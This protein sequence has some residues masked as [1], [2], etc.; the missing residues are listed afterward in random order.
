MPSLDAV[1]WDMDGTL[2]DTE[3]SWIA[4]EHAIVEE[5]GGTWNDELATQLVGHDLLVSARFII[6]NSSVTWTPERVV[7]ELISRV[8]ADLHGHVPWRPGALDLLGALRE[9]GVR[10]AL[11]TMSYAALLPP[12]LTALGDLAFDAIVTGDSV[13]RGKPHPEP[14]LTAA[15]QLGVA[16]EDCVAIEDSPT[17]VR[18]ALA[19]GIATVGVPHVV[20]LDGIRDVILVGSLTEID[21]DWLESVVGHARPA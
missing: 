2:V 4:A 15:A 13:T 20:P 5:H 21:V 8:V 18:S 9:R 6:E 16:P 3:P 12:V 14:Y 1:L 11:V 17:G 10:T 19:A 7:D